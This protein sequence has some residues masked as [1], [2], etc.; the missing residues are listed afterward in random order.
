MH[1]R[2]AAGLN[3]LFPKKTNKQKALRGN[4]HFVELLF[5]WNSSV[6]R[7]STL[8]QM[9]CFLCIGKFTVYLEFFSLPLKEQNQ[10]A[11]NT[12]SCQGRKNHNNHMAVDHLGLNGFSKSLDLEIRSPFKKKDRGDVLQGKH[13]FHQVWSL[14]HHSLLFI[15]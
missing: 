13:I 2:N 11:N 14:K 5:I 9:S 3:T 15:G 1:Q 6:E 7:L 8:K 4:S 10:K 12:W